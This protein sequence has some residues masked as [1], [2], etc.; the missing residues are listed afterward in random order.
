VEDERVGA[1]TLR[2]RFLPLADLPVACG[3]CSDRGGR[4]GVWQVTVRRDG[5]R[6]TRVWWPVLVAVLAMLGAVLVAPGPAAA[7]PDEGGSASVYK[8]LDAA[9]RKYNN[10]KAKLDATKKKQKQLTKKIA[11]TNRTVDA[12]SDEVGKIAAVRYRQGPTSLLTLALDQQSS[13][14]LLAMADTLTYLGRQDTRKIDALVAARKDQKQQQQELAETAAK[15]RKQVAELKK[16]RD[17]AQ[18]AVD[19]ISSGSSS[20]YGGQ[21]ASADPAPRNPDGSWPPESCSVDDPTT[22]GCITPRMLHAYQEARKAGYTR[23]T[24]CYRSGEDGGEHP[25]GRACDFSV[26][27]GGFGGAA[28]GEAKTYGD[29]LAAWFIANSGRLAVLYVIW[30]RQ[31][32]MPGV[33]WQHYDPTGAP[34]VE[35]TNHVH[36]SVQ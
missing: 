29:N 2:E 12:L 7:D 20:G 27:S 35:H 30:Y 19:K 18:K 26:T 5:T 22:D 4:V 8:K 14:D 33:G 17:A 15:Q 13:T 34:S 25:R 16:S 6:A 23:Y 31:I 32:W 36:L 24:A 21:S 1:S 28:S 11:A 10:A 9:A 3:A